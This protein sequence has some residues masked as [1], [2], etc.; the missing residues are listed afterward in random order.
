MESEAVIE[1]FKH[2]AFYFF[3]CVILFSFSLSFSFTE[4][5][6]IISLLVD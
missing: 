4:I 2:Y 1:Y 6:F 5:N 3:S